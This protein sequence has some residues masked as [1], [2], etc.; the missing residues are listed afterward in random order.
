M[1]GRVQIEEFFVGM[2]MIEQKWKSS[3]IIPTFLMEFNLKGILEG[4]W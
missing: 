3:G 2:Y 4:S 1:R